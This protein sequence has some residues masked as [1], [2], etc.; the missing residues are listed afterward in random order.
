MLVKIE[1][2]KKKIKVSLQQIHCIH[3][4]IQLQYNDKASLHSTLNVTR[5]FL[6]LSWDS[7]CHF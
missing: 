3:D 2:K 4:S 5:V 6:N 7:I 1:I